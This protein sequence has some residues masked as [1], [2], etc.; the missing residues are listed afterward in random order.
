MVRGIQHRD[1]TEALYYFVIS[2]QAALLL[3]K[4]NS[5]YAPVAL[6][7]VAQN[8]EIASDDKALLAAYVHGPTLVHTLPKL[9]LGLE[10]TKLPIAASAWD[11][12]KGNLLKLSR[13]T[14]L[15]C[16]LSMRR[17][18]TAR[19]SQESF[20]LGLL[21]SPAATHGE[22]PLLVRGEYALF[23]GEHELSL[24]RFSD[25]LA[26][27]LGK[28]RRAPTF[29]FNA[30]DRSVL[31]QVP[32]EGIF[33]GQLQL[34][35]DQL[36]K[37][38][39]LTLDPALA[40]LTIAPPPILT[41]TAIHDSD[42]ILG[43]RLSITPHLDWGHVKE[44]ISATYYR[45][46]AGG[47]VHIARRAAHAHYITEKDGKLILTLVDSTR[48]EHFYKLLFLNAKAL[49]LSAALECRI[50][51]DKRIA[52]YFRETWPNVLAFAHTH[53][54]TVTLNNNTLSDEHA[55]FRADFAVEMDA[56]SDEL[57]FDVACYIGDQRISIEALRD[58]VESGSSHLMLENG[59]TVQID[60]SAEL[61]RFIRMLRSFKA[62][63]DSFVGK[64]HHA[65]EL[66]YVMT[67][68]PHY[69]SRCAA[70]FQQFTEQA[71]HG[72]PLQPPVIPAHL[73][74]V[75]RPYQKEGIAWLDF[76]RSYRF[77]GILADD[78]GLGKTLQA[79]A[80]LASHKT[81]GKPHLVV[82]P[83]T[84]IYNWACE[85]GKFT[86]DLKVV[87]IDGTA[88]ERA[89]AQELSRKADLVI[90]SYSALLADKEWHSKAT[91]LYDYV[92]L[93]EAQ[94]IKNHASK[95]AMLVKKLNAEYRLAL[96]GTPLENNVVEVWSIMDFLMPGFL[97]H[98]SDF[99]D[100][101]GKPIMQTNDRFALEQLRRK[102]TV[103][104]LRR[105]KQ[106][107][108]KELP[109][110]IEQHAPVALS[111]DQRILYG[112]ILAQVR[113]SIEANVAANG[114]ARSYIHILSGLMKLR[115]V[116]N[117][118]ALLLEENDPARKEATSSKMDLAIEL[119]GEALAGNT[120]G[121]AQ[122]HKVLV[123]SQF[124]GML[125][126]LGEALKSQNI[127]FFTLTGKTQH[128][129]ALVEK[130]NTDKETCV[131]LIST[132]A[133]GTGLNLASADTVIVIDPWWNPSV[134]RQAIDRAHR[135][136][137]TRSVNV[138]RLITTGTI[139]EKIQALQS[140][141]KDLFDALVNETGSTL[142]KLTWD[143][144]RSL[145]AD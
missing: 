25:P 132:K 18:L 95:T 51:G 52:T 36:K 106:E 29:P 3:Y 127:P 118:P 130:F 107:V 76:L 96:T 134:E 66:K 104:M 60:N 97:G 37:E 47:K 114:F 31:L 59:T 131:F 92:V 120:E 80:F 45:S 2:P 64:L 46:T 105:T 44:D 85:A 17:V 145:F 71:E 93:D 83:K 62:R 54:L 103:F 91:T 135:I 24:H 22:R 126:L 7:E 41:L 11:F 137:Q 136:G 61:S 129:Q 43:E 42:P 50:S 48:A 32:V 123:F 8:N 40:K 70:S 23:F 144:V 65:P 30:N 143:D 119:I 112:E 142:A 26:T 110:K 49:G 77:G 13:K 63:Q 15:D 109:P 94:F 84:L 9:F 128:R 27:L 56:E 86:P 138:Y 141:K 21:S 125:D 57:S 88:S 28:I 116:C 19:G 113:N 124:T 34:L 100:R 73:E 140:K 89:E 90:T 39:N 133:G 35:I 101:Y 16:T 33:L 74:G 20:A 1:K 82:C 4:R 115:Q 81:P 121:D 38:T 5:P 69:N 78:M 122:P 75:L 55:I 99:I 117:H 72:T 102:I 53:G 87:T 67:C 79:L 6:T 68:S 12:Q 58:F 14:K 108:L 111:P 98:H 10:Q 139:E